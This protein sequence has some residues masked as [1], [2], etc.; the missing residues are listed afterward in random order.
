PNGVT[1]SYVG[2]DAPRSASPAQITRS[3]SPSPSPMAVGMSSDAAGDAPAVA[4]AGGSVAVPLLGAGFPPGPHAAAMS[5]S[6]ASAPPS[7]RWNMPPP[8]ELD[9]GV[10]PGRGACAVAPRPAARVDPERPALPWTMCAGS[11]A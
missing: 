3:S 11:A 7:L 8:L 6:T 4:P 2:S 5:A 10:T 9:S 1:Q